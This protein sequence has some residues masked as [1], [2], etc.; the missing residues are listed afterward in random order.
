[1]I[2]SDREWISRIRQLTAD[3][4]AALMRLIEA[5]AS[6]PHHEPIAPPSPQSNQLRLLIG[7]FDEQSSREIKQAVQD[8]EQVDLDQWA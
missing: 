6:P 8:L 7:L 5:F 3:Q 2:M 1:M 4:Q